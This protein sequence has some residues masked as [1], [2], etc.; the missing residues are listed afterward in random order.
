MPSLMDIVQ[1][2]V[3]ESLIPDILADR[4]ITALVTGSSGYFGNRL[5]RELASS[6]GRVRCL[7]LAAPEDPLP[8]NCE[9]FKGNLLDEATVSK[10]LKGCHVVFHTASAG[11]S[12]SSQLDEKLCKRVNV[13]GTNLILSL[14]VQHSVERLVYTSSYNVIF[15]KNP[16][17]NCTEDEPY[18]EDEEQYDW[19]S[20]TKKEA[21]KTVLNANGTII[22]NGL[23]LRTCALRPNGI[24]GENEKKH[25][26]RIADRIEQGVTIFKFGFGVT[27][28]DWC[29]VENLVQAHV[30]AA[31]KL[32]NRE[33]RI[34]AGKAYNISDDNPV[35]PYVFLKPVFDAMDQPL[36]SITIPYILVFYIA[37]LSEILH[38]A[39]KPFCYFEPIVTRNECAKVCTTHTCLMDKARRELDYVPRE[40]KFAN[41]VAIMM[42]E[43]KRKRQWK[44]IIEDNRYKFYIAFAIF[45]CL[46]YFLLFLW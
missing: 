16:L 33:N 29:H 35:N 41:A 19:Y 10:A 21:E 42:K 24:Y 31:R 3:P 34:A 13:D 20:R 45:C 14:C 27:L 44:D 12:G 9:F 23:R 37:W 8:K 40:Y 15:S 6:Y 30:K 32:T 1:M 46:Y 22:A 7:D 25:L 43:R 17:F 36:P 4:N 28:L 5:V 2:T 39:L 26:P 18:P 11:M 38:T